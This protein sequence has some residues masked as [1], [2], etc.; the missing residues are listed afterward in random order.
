MYKIYDL[1]LTLFPSFLCY[2]TFLTISP[3]FPLSH[4]V[5]LP[6]SL[7]HTLSLPCLDPFLLLTFDSCIPLSLP[8]L[9]H[10]P[11][12]TLLVSTTLPYLPFI[13]ALHC[14]IQPTCQAP[15]PLLSLLHPRL[16]YFILTLWLPHPASS[17]LPAHLRSS[18]L[19]FPN[20]PTLA[21]LL[22]FCLTHSASRTSSRNSSPLLDILLSL[23][24]LLLSLSLPLSRFNLS[25]C[26]NITT[27]PP[28]SLLFHLTVLET[29]LGHSPRHSPHS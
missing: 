3:C 10:T 6:Y 1:P 18:Y 19:A 15:V 9:T 16:T 11:R 26:L 27:P 14:Q 29:P 21:S 25:I 8:C 4:T 7:S 23:S 28:H 5:S 24:S 12:I 22:L 2:S 20:L 17:I 13:P